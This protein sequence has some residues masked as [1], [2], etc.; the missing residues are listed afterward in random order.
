[1]TALVNL[2]HICSKI[3]TWYASLPQ[4]RATCFTPAQLTSALNNS[5]SQL[6]EPLILLKWN[7]HKVWGRINKKRILRVYYTP[8]GYQIIKPK[9][10]RPPINLT[11]LLGIA[12]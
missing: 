8:P 7:H 4:P 2:L 1:M 9:R 3:T 10:G 12:S 11:E 5:M 6:Y